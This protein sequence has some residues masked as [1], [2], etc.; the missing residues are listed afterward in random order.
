MKKFSVSVLLITLLLASCRAPVMQNRRGTGMQMRMGQNN[1]MMDRHHT[2]VPNAYRG[3]SSPVAADNESLARGAEI[4]TV[5]CASCHGDGG[6]GDGPAGKVLDPAASPV[7]HTSQMLGDDYLFWRI[8]EGG[9]AFDSAMPPWKGLLDEQSRWDL[10]NYMRAL[11]S[12]DVMPRRAMGGMA[13]DPDQEVAQRQEMLDT[14]VAQGMISQEE[15]QTFIV[16]HQAMDTLMAAGSAE[17]MRG[18][19]NEQLAIMLASLTESGKITQDQSESF[20]DV[21]ERL[22]DAGLMQ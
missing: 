11:G 15:A 8:S 20:Q 21:H 13:F 1:G 18:N 22:I 10:I 4:Y 9:A 17:P 3:V 14:A 7:A 16:V 6:M 5:N 19:M 12:G 2:A